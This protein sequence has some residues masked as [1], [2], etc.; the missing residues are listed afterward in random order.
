MELNPTK[1]GVN[2]HIVRRLRQLYDQVPS[3][4]GTGSTWELPG[5]VRDGLLGSPKS[6]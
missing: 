2:A 5:S 1:S 6:T 3:D 4:Q